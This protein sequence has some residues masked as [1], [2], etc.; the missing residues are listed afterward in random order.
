MNMTGEKSKK[1]SDKFLDAEIKKSDFTRVGVTGGKSWNTVKSYRFSVST[2]EKAMQALRVY[3]DN[4]HMR[5]RKGLTGIYQ[6]CCVYR[7]SDGKASGPSEWTEQV[8]FRGTKALLRLLPISADTNIGYRE[9]YRKGGDLGSDARL[10]FTIYDNATTEYWSD[11][12][13]SLLGKLLNYEVIPDSTI[14]VPLCGKWGP[15]FKGRYILYRD[16][17]DLRAWYYSLKDLPHAWS[18]LQRGRMDSDILDIFVLDDVL[19]FNTKNG[20]R[21]LSKDPSIAGAADLQETG[22]VKHSMG[23]WASCK[24]EEAIAVVSYDGVYVFTGHNHR[25]IS[26]QVEDHF[27]SASYDLSEAVEFYR[28]RHLYVSVITTG[29]TRKLLD[30]FIERS[31]WRKSD[32]VVNCFCV[33]DGIGDN[34]EIY[35]GD[36]TGSVYQFD[37]GYTSSSEAVTKDY[38]ADPANPFAEVVLQEIF[39]MARS[40]SASPGVINVQF[41][42]NQLLNAGIVKSFPSTGNLTSTYTLYHGQLMA[43]NNYLK[44]SKIGLAIT[45]GTLGKHFAIESIL[46]IGEISDL[47]E[48]Y[49]G[50]TAV[51]AD[52]FIFLGRLSSDPTTSDWGTLEAGRY[53]WFNTTDNHWKGWSGTEIVILG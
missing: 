11:T 8:T 18:E 34:D 42:M 52:L 51:G 45:P 15:V 27:D 33:A 4:L 10:D 25:Y 6:W 26:E 39:M 2:T 9:F 48:I 1:L 22:L 44:G 21:S 7:T 40:A 3:F 12:V 31:A 46:L 24:V 19:Y 13:D 38:A 36:L 32:Y 23:P 20:L 43:V 14:R 35:I 47:P 17:S 41:R 5:R 30:Y 29:G 28:N 53:V 37:T 49:E 50:D 16:P